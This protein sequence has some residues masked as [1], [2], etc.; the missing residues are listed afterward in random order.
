M[1][2]K[3]QKLITLTSEFCDQYLDEDHK[4]LTQKMISTLCKKEEVDFQ[5]EELKNWA[6]AVIHALGSINY[7]F[8]NSFEPYISEEELIDYF[9]AHQSHIQDKS[10]EIK[11]LL[12]LDLFDNLSSL[13]RF[14]DN[15]HLHN[16]L[17]IDGFFLNLETFP[18]D[19]QERIRKARNQWLDVAFS[20]EED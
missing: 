16:L 3:K 17:L 1:T 15:E 19:L 7:L 20:S 14:Q 11:K 5:H 4:E 8:D 12:R 6:A 13:K 18:P 9:N 10:R 2:E